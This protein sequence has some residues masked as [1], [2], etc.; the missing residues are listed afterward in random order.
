MLGKVLSRTLSMKEFEDWL[1][2]VDFIKRQIVKND[3]IFEFVT[4]DL[5][6]RDAFVELEK[7]YVKYFGKEAC[8]VDVLK[9]NCELLVHTKSDETIDIFFQNICQFQDWNTEYTLLA[10]IHYLLYD[11]QLSH[12]GYFDPETTKNEIYH[13]AAIVCEKLN[14]LPLEES[15]GFLINGVETNT[16]TPKKEAASKGNPGE[17]VLKRKKWFP[18]FGKKISN[19]AK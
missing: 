5:R 3:M 6:H 10:D 1:Y 8:L 18:F 9:Y 19:Y 13:F 16:T 12:D 2:F 15:V 14:K 4:I 7:F 17:T 11:W